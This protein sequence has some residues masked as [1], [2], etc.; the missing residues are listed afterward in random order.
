[1][2]RPVSSP[3]ERPCAQC[4]KGFRPK[5]AGRPPRYCSDACKQRA[6]EGRRTAAAM[7]KAEREE[8]AKVARMN[9]RVT[10]SDVE[11]RQ[12]E[13]LAEVEAQLAAQY[14]ADHEA[15]RD[16]VEQANRM[17]AEV[18]AEIGGRSEAMGLLEKFRPHVGTIWMDRG[19]NRLASRRA[20]LRKV[21]QSRAEADARRAKVEVDRRT[22]EICT[23]LAAGGLTSPE[24]QAFLDAM[25]RV[26]ELLPTLRMPELD[27]AKRAPDLRVIEA[28]PA[29]DYDELDGGDAS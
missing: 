10:K 20:E 14:R 23:Q 2:T 29:D 25:P 9:A 19:E 13:L 12:R 24:A 5:A 3:D 11:A 18:D 15:W 4:G 22:A 6:Y 17:L 1:M 27:T 28:S 7:T 16:L 8:L 26:D 21:A